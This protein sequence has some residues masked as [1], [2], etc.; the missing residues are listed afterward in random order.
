MQ[1]D[2]IAAL[3]AALAKAQGQLESAKRDSENPFYRSRYADL[4]SVWD[5]CRK[6][7]SAN[8]LAVVQ[9]TKTG[10]AGTLLVTTLAHS[11]G[12]WIRG[13]YPLHPMRQV[14]KEGWVPSDD[15]QAIGSALTYA[16]RYAL[17]AIVGVAPDDD[18]DG[19]AAMGRPAQQ[20]SRPTGRKPSDTPCPSCG[21]VGSLRK[22]K[23]KDGSAD[24]WYCFKKA[25]GCGDKF[26]SDPAE[27][28]LPIE[29]V[30][31]AKVNECRALVEMLET[32]PDLDEYVR[33]LVATP[34]WT[35]S[36]VATQETIKAAVKRRRAELTGDA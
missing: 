13:E 31:Q 32:V 29:D 18:D 28:T 15:P 9:T 7:L 2:S 6:A 30:D 12:E 5:A 33:Q 25:G 35:A 26:S 16:R 24:E 3:A 8:G 19:E 21:V 34:E 11:S 10:E 22:G 14:Q 27:S 4:A 36:T 17:A 20:A 23:T 1:S